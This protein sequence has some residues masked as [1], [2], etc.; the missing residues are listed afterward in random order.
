MLFLITFCLS[1]ETFNNFLLLF[2]EV[3]TNESNAYGNNFLRVFF[4]FD[5]LVPRIKLYVCGIS[6]IMFARI[7][8][9]YSS[10]FKHGVLNDNSLK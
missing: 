7:S 9:F 2:F 10:T 6:L 3:H 5:S 4:S 8:S 1:Q